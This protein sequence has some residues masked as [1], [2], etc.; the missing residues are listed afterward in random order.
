VAVQI[1]DTLEELLVQ[2]A[3]C[4]THEQATE[5][6]RTRHEIAT[7]ARKKQWQR[8]HRGV[9]YALPGPVPRLA[10][11]WAAQLRVG[12][13]GVLSHETAAEMWGFADE[14]SDPIHV[15]VPRTAGTL[16][17][18]EGIRL[19]YSSRLPK[20]EFGAARGSGIP[21]LT[22]AQ[23]AVLDLASTSPTAPDAVN[24]AIR[25]CQRGKT[26]PDLIAMCML[27]P[28]QRLLRWRDELTSAL[29]DVRLGVQSPLEERYLRDVERAH[30]L[31]E[32]RR[33]VK[34]RKGTSAQF[35]D[36][37]YLDY[38]AGVE[39][40]AIAYHRGDAVD[41]DNARDNSGV[42][43][44]VQT[45]RYGWLRVAYHPCEVAHEVWTLL[46]RNGYREDFRR[47]GPSCAAPTVPAA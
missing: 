17:P 10:W 37:R 35:H 4:V 16:P 23:F 5:R 39:L 46:V 7:L 28:G 21:P 9:Y 29:A 30:R 14:Q 6:G 44:E 8:L 26:T 27:E 42:L 31:P 36:V 24:W 1:P 43:P 40:D 38:G 25:A 18:T 2:Q 22:W 41:R 45:L 13:G 3:H 34:T 33:Q 15:S 47:C 11:L 12:H 19:H 20:A 32:G